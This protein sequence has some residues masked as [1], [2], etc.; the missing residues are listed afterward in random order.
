M[1]CVPSVQKQHRYNVECLGR[2][3]ADTKQ[4]ASVRLRRDYQACRPLSY[5]TKKSITCCVQYHWGWMWR[6]EIMGTRSESNNKI[7]RHSSRVVPLNPWRT[8]HIF[9]MHAL[10]FFAPHA[11]GSSLV[12]KP[13]VLYSSKGERQFD[14]SLLDIVIS[15]SVPVRANS[16]CAIS[17]HIPPHFSKCANSR[18]LS[19]VGCFT[20]CH[21]AR[22]SQTQPHHDRVSVDRLGRGGHFSA[23]SCLTLSTKSAKMAMWKGRGGH[24]RADI[25][26]IK[27]TPLSFGSSINDATRPLHCRSAR[28]EFVCFAVR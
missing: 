13:Y 9:W 25:N 18:H 3:Y 27:H 4:T 21:F 23:S 16:M 6:R 22:S 19:K 28:N 1:L 20:A 5:D 24:C 7:W 17:R 10:T 12:H 26:L 11:D 15:R 8:P 2:M 14:D